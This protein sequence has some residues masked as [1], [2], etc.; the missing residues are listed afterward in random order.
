MPG[1]VRLGDIC[2]GHG[3]YPPRPNV[4][5]SGNVI[6]N[7]RGAHR[8]GDGWAAHGCGVCAPH[9]SIQGSGSPNVMTNNRAQA[10]CGD[11]VACGSANATCSGN[12]IAN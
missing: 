4:S 9:G 11:A 2:T 8:V 12:V 7:S 3:C 10:R 1:C 5:A 6:I